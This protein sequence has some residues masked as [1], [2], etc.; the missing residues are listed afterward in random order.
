[1]L[2][3]SYGLCFRT[4]SGSRPRSMLILNFEQNVIHRFSHDPST[5]ICSILGGEIF[6]HRAEFV[7]WFLKI[8]ADEA[9]FPH[10]VTFTNGCNFG[11]DDYIN[12]NA[13]V[14]LVR[15]QSVFVNILSGVTGNFM[16][17]G[18]TTSQIYHLYTELLKRFLWLPAQWNPTSLLPGLETLVWHCVSG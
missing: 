10:R 17:S 15:Q 13:T 3:L 6:P 12:V 8:V 5:S 4:H 14:M 11:L 1:M 9:D 2:H 7:Q 18:S 16:C